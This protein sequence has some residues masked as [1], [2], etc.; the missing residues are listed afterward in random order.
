MAELRTGYTTGACAA[1]AAKAAAMVMGD[2]EAPGIVSI[3]LA[4]GQRAELGICGWERLPRGAR[5]ST[6]KDAGDDPDITHGA[7]ISAEVSLM[8]DGDIDFAAGEGVGMVTRKGLTIPPGQPAINPGPRKMITMAVRE[9]TDRPV[10]VRV[11]IEGGKD[12]AEKTFNPRLG[13]VGG[14][15]ILGTTGIVRPYSCP[16]L[17]Q[18]ILCSL[19]VA[20]AEG[21]RNLVLTPG[22]IGTRAAR[23]IFGVAPSRIV[24]VGNEWGY[25]L[26]RMAGRS[27][28]G[29]LVAGHPGKL[30]KLAMGQWDT[31]SSRSDSAAPYVCAL[32]RE[33]VGWQGEE[34]QTVE[35]VFENLPEPDREKLGYVLAK[36]IQKAVNEKTG[37]SF[38]VSVALVNM[39][40]RL[41]GLTDGAEAW[42]K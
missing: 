9:V 13:V 18:A 4:N 22:N 30:A 42:R 19:D 11:S 37:Q 12:L 15:S 35:G 28:D 14:L 17:R 7:R 26:E 31:H 21:S 29:I 2:M 34:S 39:K 32:A 3:T 27:L 1:A 10:M 40:G 23:D 41:S 16:A 33:H 36:E 8:E 25:V 38:E 20:L 6:I 24:E 5:A